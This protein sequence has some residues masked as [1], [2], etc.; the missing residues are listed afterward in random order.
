[1]GAGG[2][3]TDSLMDGPGR[4]KCF[5]SFFNIYYFVFW[6]C[7][8]LVVALGFFDFWCSLQ[9]LSCSMQTLS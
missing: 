4:Q 8:V 3:S 7:Q 6:L 1:M 2:C 9:I 5:V